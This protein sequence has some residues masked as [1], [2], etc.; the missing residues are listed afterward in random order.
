MGLISIL[1]GKLSNQEEMVI[2]S[3]VSG[4]IHK[5]T[6]SMLGMFANTL[7]LKVSP[8][9]GKVFGDYL[10][11]LKVQALKAQE[12]QAYPFEELVDK[13]VGERDSSRNP[14]FDVMMVYQNNEDIEP[15]LGTGEWQT[16]KN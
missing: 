2:G 11:E 16:L 8:S 13:V 3:P 10:E 14:L 5:D 6:E 7:A 12:H 1:L 15:L 9:G 4:R